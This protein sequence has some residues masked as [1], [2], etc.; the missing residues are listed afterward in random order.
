MTDTFKITAYDRTKDVVTVDFV[1][2]AKGSFSGGTFIG[3]K[4][5]G[6]PKDSVAGV[7]SYFRAYADGYIN[8]KI[9]E[10]D[11]QADIPLDV[12]ALLNTATDF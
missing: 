6:I 2:G 11:K 1:L 4:L 9:N 3:V 10:T 12:Q 7:K 8:G 5:S